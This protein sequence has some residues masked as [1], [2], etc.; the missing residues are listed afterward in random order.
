MK[1]FIPFKGMPAAIFLKQSSHNGNE[2]E[3][4]M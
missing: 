2:I 3:D 1:P 4:Q